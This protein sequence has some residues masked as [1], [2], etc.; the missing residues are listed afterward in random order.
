M[1]REARMV[2][3]DRLLASLDER[4]LRV[5]LDPVPAGAKE[6]APRWFRISRTLSL[7]TRYNFRNGNTDEAATVEVTLE[8]SLP[9]DWSLEI[10]GGGNGQSI[11][12]WHSWRF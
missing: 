1:A 8:W 4:A 7:Y 12:A 10:R 11:S 9:R 2:R 3:G 6:P 5:L